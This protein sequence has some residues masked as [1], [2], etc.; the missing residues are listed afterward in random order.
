MN[1]IRKVATTT[2]ATAL[3]RITGAMRVLALGFVFGTNI[4]ADIFQ[5]A[6]RLPNLFR[7]IFGEGLFA[8]HV[9]LFTQELTINK[10]PGLIKIS[11]NVFSWLLLF[12][13]FFTLVLELSADLL[14]GLIAPAL[15]EDPENF[16][17]LVLVTRV[18][19]LYLPLISTTVFFCSIRHAFNKFFTTV[20]IGCIFNIVVVISLLS[21]YFF[22]YSQANILL[23]IGYI[24]IAIGVVEMVTL[25]VLLYRKNIVIIPHFP[26]YNLNIKEIGLKI[27]FLLAQSA[28]SY[29]LAMTDIYF[30]SNQTGAIATYHYAER[31][32]LLP[33][34]LLSQGIGLVLLTVLAEG[35]VANN[36][37]VFEKIYQSFI[38]ALFTSLFFCIVFVVLNKEIVAFVLYRG[39]FTYE[40][41]LLTSEF[42]LILSLFIP[43]LTCEII[44]SRI[45]YSRK[46][47][48]V[49]FYIAVSAFVINIIGNIVLFNIFGVIGIIYATTLAV[50]VR[51][52]LYVII[53]IVKREEFIT[54]KRLLSNSAKILFAAALLCIFLYN[55]K[56]FL[57]SYTMD[58]GFF[59]LLFKLSLLCGTGFIVYIGIVSYFKILTISTI[60]GFFKKDAI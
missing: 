3:S 28:F 56:N 30:L 10:T 44:F 21:L 20:F 53:F 48:K 1:F 38:I 43:F 24:V 29:M 2:I 13:I 51:F 26:T 19:I 33:V 39:S 15:Q 14:L 27:P 25:I 45:F 7:R 6:W 23:H 32:V 42:F 54:N 17:L 34:G 49:P 60:K 22:H 31:F 16:E 40:S 52:F 8:I 4:Y 37:R 46:N 35:Y 57:D 5:I 50:I 58:L 55:G 11:Q 9:P 36:K 47:V 41:L 59:T 12:L 18:F